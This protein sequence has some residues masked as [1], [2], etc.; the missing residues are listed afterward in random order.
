MKTLTLTLF[1]ALTCSVGFAQNNQKLDSLKLALTNAA[2]D[3]LRVLIYE[4][5]MNA[6]PDGKKQ[7]EFGLAGFALAKRIHFE[8]GIVLCGNKV[9]LLLAHQEHFKAIPILME[10]KQVAEK[11]NDKVGF[12]TS[13]GY[14]GYAY[15]KFDAEK[16]LDYYFRCKGLM[17]KDKISE[18]ILAISLVLGFHYK[19]DNKNLDSAL[20]Y[21]NKS[22]QLSLKSKIYA[23]PPF[24]H[25]RHFG[26]VCY[27][28]GQKDLALDYFRKSVANSGGVNEYSYY[29]IALIFRE[30]NQLD[31]A[32]YYAQKSLNLESTDIAIESATL[33]FELYQQDDP[34]KALKYHIIASE[35]KDSRFNQNKIAQANKLLF[36]DQEREATIKRK[37]EAEQ[38]EYK[39]KVKMY[40][41]FGGL[42]GLSILAL[43][44]FLL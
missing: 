5:L 40:A 38:A 27:N 29:Y 18:E 12:A 35:E 16:S 7:I 31:S 41:L 20:Y 44:L 36:E 8:K 33:L 11:T 28:K 39:S 14:L 22:Y 42:F 32:K 37:V 43:L 26:Q 9:G 1:L 3:T 17:E 30:R 13:I 15:G 24:A 2:S 25:Y 6:E 23:Y 19:A 21:L 10:A 4:K 34:A